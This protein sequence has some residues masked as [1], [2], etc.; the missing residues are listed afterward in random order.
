MLSLS[1]AP[2]LRDANIRLWFANIR[3]ES[4]KDDSSTNFFR[5]S[6]EHLGVGEKTLWIV[7]GG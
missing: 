7:A 3:T 4:L 1:D 5:A 2:H 6:M